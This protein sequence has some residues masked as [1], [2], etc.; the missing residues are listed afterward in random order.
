MDTF[1][2]DDHDELTAGIVPVAGG[3]QPDPQPLDSYSTHDHGDLPQAAG[4]LPV[5]ETKVVAAPEPPAPQPAAVEA[6]VAAVQP[7]VPP[8]V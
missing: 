1:Q 2:S 3:A 6:E 7:P 5:V 8:Q 4:T